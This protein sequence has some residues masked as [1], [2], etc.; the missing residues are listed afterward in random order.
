MDFPKTRRCRIT[1]EEA[2][3]GAFDIPYT[4]DFTV[5]DVIRLLPEIANML[6]SPDVENKE[7]S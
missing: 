3:D 5:D 1:I 6:A 7:I 4:E 2:F